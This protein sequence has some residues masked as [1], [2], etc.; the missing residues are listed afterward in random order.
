MGKYVLWFDKIN[1]E[2]IPLVGGKGANLGEMFNVGLPIPPG[3]VVTTDAFKEFLEQTGL[4]K[5]INALLKNID[6]ENYESL[7]KASEEIQKAIIAA[8]MPK[9]IEEE[10]IK[11]YE[12]LSLFEEDHHLLILPKK[13][14]KDVLV[15]VRSSATAEDLG[16]A[17]FAGQQATYLNIKGKEMLIEAVKKDWASLYTARAIYY[18]EKEGFDH[19]KVLIAVVVQ[20]M[21]QS[22]ISGIMFTANPVTNN[23]DEITIEA[24]FGLGEA[25][26]SGEV[27]P[28]LYIVDKKTMTIKHK[29][30]H[31]QD[32]M[33]VRDENGTTRTVEVPK[34]LKEVQ[35]MSDDLI[36]ELA[37]Y[38]LI[39]ERHYGKPMD[40]EWAVEKGKIFIVQARPITTI[41]KRKAEE[42]KKVDGEEGK[43]RELLRGLPASPGIASGKVKIIYSADEIDKVEKG[44]VLV[45][46]M[47]N[48]DMVP[49]MEKAA[50]I[51]TDEGGITSH[52]AIVSRELGVPCIVGTEKA[53]KVL[54]N[55][56]VVTVDA[57]KGVVYEGA[58]NKE[59]KKEKV[60]KEIDNEQLEN[61]IKEIE[62]LETTATEIKLIQDVP[63]LAEKM[64]KLEV[65]G[66]G[67]MR[68]EFAVA[69]G[70]IHPAEYLRSGK[71]K[72][73]EN[74]V[75][76]KVRKT[77]KAFYPRPVWVRTLDM[78]TDEYTELK[79]GD[80]EPKE[81]NP[82]LGWHGIRRSLDQPELL[83]AELRAIKRLHDEG[84]TN[85]GVMF[86]F[87]IRAE[88]VRKAREIMEKVGLDP[89][90]VE[91]GV[92]VETPAAVWT[93]EDIIKEGIKFIS[94]G[95]ND[96]TQLT[97]GIDRNNQ[98]IAKLFS[99][100][101][102]AVIKEIEHVIKECKKHGVKTSI[103]G[104]AG[105]NPEMAQKLV[106]LGI[107]SI[108]V[109]PDAVLKV[110]K[111]VAR[112]EKKLLLE[113]VR[114]FLKE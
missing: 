31:K 98:R 112:A 40:I 77:A 109:N 20:K 24:G 12:Q 97:L 99:E 52:A 74:L 70:G 106:E 9:E 46:T 76:E 57:Y 71:I 45:T 64:A 1:K 78:R 111:A 8:P 5:K 32:I 79:G 93:I 33:I 26:V 63:H 95:T 30:I 21:V 58:L 88:E 85:V 18:R 90:K 91:W 68:M 50:A 53:T 107:D 104:Q 110:K 2:S 34:H 105:S 73:Y 89:N 100:L 65:D 81:D 54:K 10:I 114:K 23:L 11:A 16:G 41:K 15:A 113:G 44:D 7:K 27:N 59:K 4:G 80:K 96:L 108:S 67:L 62:A 56:Q 48:P 92:M 49:A 19:S 43:L 37:K 38:G 61:L 69:E 3:F 29:E 39:I 83:E 6:I 25:L 51:V 102:P 66:V 22:E 47:T 17:S 60:V 72:D 28:D 101:H 42:T 87:V 75:Y 36:I 82:M 86:P 35:K 55:G 14:K 103:C 94:F 84:L 13:S